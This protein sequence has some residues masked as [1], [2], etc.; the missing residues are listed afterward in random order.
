MAARRVPRGPRAEAAMD[1]VAVRAVARRVPLAVVV[2]PPAPRVL[3]K[4]IMMPSLSWC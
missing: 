4:L 2:V 1:T 3:R